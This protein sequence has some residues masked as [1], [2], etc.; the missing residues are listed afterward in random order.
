MAHASP[1]ESR[2][3]APDDRAA[4]GTPSL[5]GTAAAGGAGRKRSR[6]PTR[7]RR[8][9]TVL[10]GVLALCCTGALAGGL[11]LV[12]AVHG[13]GSPAR[14]AVDAFLADL[15]AGRVDA[16][17]DRLCARTRGDVDRARFAE[18]VAQ[19]PVTGYEIDDVSAASL[20][21]R[22]AAVVST[23]LIVAGGRVVE[24]TVPVTEEGDEWR[25][26]GD[27]Y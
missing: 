11:M 15:V 6:R 7:R 27:P 17:Y 8:S 4:G 18:A 26:C 21:T 25:V 1:A 20:G 16:A 23:R 13:I 10:A 14:D 9:P 2:P 5:G 19:R 22:G 12:R 24:H 3:A